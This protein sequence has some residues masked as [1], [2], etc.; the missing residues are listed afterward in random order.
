MKT[1]EDLT[2]D[3]IQDLFDSIIYLRGEEYYDEGYISLIEPLDSQ[4]IKGIVQG[5]RKYHVSISIDAEGKITCECS[6]P[7]D[8][9]YALQAQLHLFHQR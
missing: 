2:I 7:C 9:R 1:I 4:T 6:C 3:D 8:F 5:T